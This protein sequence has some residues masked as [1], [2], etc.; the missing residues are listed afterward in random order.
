MFALRVRALPRPPRA[1]APVRFYATKPK[2]ADAKLA[3][4]PAAAP[5]PTAGTATAQSSCAP[6]TVLEGLNYLK[7]QPPVLA[8]PDAAYPAWL[9]TLL[10]SK[11]ELP[12]DGPG[13][14]AEKRRLRRENRQRIRDQ[15]FM[16][17]Q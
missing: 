8:Q 15:N 9:W 6:N 16:K 13:G 1:L 12:D 14:H 10:D 3:P 2:K 11:A 7:D 4:L 5:A 17:T